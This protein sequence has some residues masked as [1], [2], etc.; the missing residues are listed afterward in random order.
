M[1]QAAETGSCPLPRLS[2]GI[3]PAVLGLALILGL[4]YL[5]PT[6]LLWFRGPVSPGGHLPL[7][8]FFVV[9][10]LLLVRKLPRSLR[11]GFSSREIRAVFGI[12]TI[13]LAGF[14]AVGFLIAVLPMPYYN[15]RPPLKEPVVFLLPYRRLF[16]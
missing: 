16:S 5:L 9:L 4:A 7:I 6:Y 10:L 2:R 15:I 13:G 8:P 12:L 1:T 14:H 11:L 3:R